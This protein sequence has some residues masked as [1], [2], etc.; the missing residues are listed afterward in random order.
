MCVLFYVLLGRYNPEIIETLEE[1]V[2]YQVD[3]GTYD[4]E[5]N[6]VLMKLY[7]FQPEKSNIEI[8]VKIMLKAIVV[9][10][11]PDFVLLRCVLSEPL[12]SYTISDK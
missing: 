6:L 11:K 7:Q 2:Q 10:P 8:A 9:L 4:F 3:S 12:V 1:Y 5:P